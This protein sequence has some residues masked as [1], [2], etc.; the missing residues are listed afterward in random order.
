MAVR[1]R[2]AMFTAVLASA[3]VMLAIY[4]PVQ[5]HRLQ[6]TLTT[7][8]RQAQASVAESLAR[9]LGHLMESDVRALEDLASVLATKDLHN[10]HATSPLL[11][12]YRTRSGAADMVVLGSSLGVALDAAPDS[13]FGQLIRGTNY[14]DRDYYRAIVATGASTMSRLQAGRRTRRLN[15]QIAA[16]IWGPDRRLAGYVSASLPLSRFIHYGHQAIAHLP[17]GRVVVTDREGAMVVDT[18]TST[19]ERV[20]HVGDHPLFAAASAQNAQYRQ[21]LDERGED[22][23]AAVSLLGGDAARFGWTVVVTQ[24]TRYV[25][26]TASDA[27]DFALAATLAALSLAA[28]VAMLLSYWIARP[29]SQLTE[30]AR[31]VASGRDVTLPAASS[32]RLDVHEATELR[33]AVVDMVQTLR[34]HA[35]QLEARV[36][37]RTQVLAAQAQELERAR[38]QALEAAQL[39]SQFLANMSHEIRTPMNGVLGMT[40]LLLDTQLSPDQREYSE[41]AHV[42]ATHLLELLNEILDYSKI[43]A[44]R[45]QF[46]ELPFDVGEALDDVVYL[47]RGKAAEKGLD[48]LP[49]YQLAAGRW[50]RGDP[51]RVRQIVTNLL[52]NAL[53]FTPRGSISLLLDSRAEGDRLHIDITVSDTG[54]G[55]AP[56]ALE[57]IFEVFTQA[58]ATTTRRFGGS[59]LGLAISRQLARAMGGELTVESTLGVGSTFVARLVLPRAPEAERRRPSPA[60][61]AA[62]LQVIAARSPARDQLMEQLHGLSLT[63]AVY[64][65]LSQRPPTTGN[66]TCVVIAESPLDVP[67]TSRVWW[68][69]PG[70]RGGPPDQAEQVD[71]VLLRPTRDERLLAT[72]ESV[73]TVAR[74]S[75]LPP[76]GSDEAP[77][78]LRGRVLLV[79]DNAINQ[80]VAMRMLERLDVRVDVAGNG[81]EAL[82]MVVRLPYDLVLMDCQMPELDGFQATEQIRRMGGAVSQL[83]IVALTANAMEA[84]RQRC[85]AAG[86]N[87][88]LAKPLTAAALRGAIERWLPRS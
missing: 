76:R 7:Q 8:S 39:K 55:I 35:Q 70:P 69:K 18:T 71:V 23:E 47:L 44:G 24:P 64:D 25:M 84:D 17:E 27:R 51:G 63:P 53:K 66:G 15:V 13:A 34:G 61:A 52:G 32:A 14:S 21:G 78:E 77:G 45:L 12:G 86:M 59:G 50:V 42:S 41:A 75:S 38:N 22:V 37:E 29:I 3:A 60:L 1:L 67:G 4:G 81:R 46:E 2:A 48:L 68:T 49:R 43:E 82:E 5:A 19:S 73:V 83:P 9:E 20:R 80:K 72:L 88:H 54:I 87:E 31:Q 6:A 11:A 65:D 74:K 26:Q 40:G 85:L 28:A 16:P 30:L 33:G 79:E 57:H 36:T 56:E 10:T 62:S 58:D